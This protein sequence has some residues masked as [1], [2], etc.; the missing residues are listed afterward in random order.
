VLNAADDELSVM[1]YWVTSGE[2]EFVQADPIGVW[3]AGAA[4]GTMVVEFNW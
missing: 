3:A 4:A 2:T 1:G